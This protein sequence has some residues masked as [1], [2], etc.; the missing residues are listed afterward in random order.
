[1]PTAFS[2]GCPAFPVTA[3][4]VVFLNRFYWPDTAAT[5]QMLTDLAEGLAARGWEVS[6]IAGA[7]AYGAAV[8]AASRE[9]RNGVRIFRVRGTSLG[10]DRV[11]FRAIDQGTYMLASALRLGRIPRT[12][13]V[14]AMSDPPLVLA[15]AVALARARGHRVVYWL[16]DVYPQLAARLGVIRE[17]GI[18][19]RVWAALLRALYARCGAI[20]A[21][22]PAMAREAVVAGA[23]PDRTVVVSNWADTSA[24]RP[25]ASGASALAQAHGLAGKFVVLYSGNAGLAHTFE[26]VIAAA[27][28]LRDDPRIV[29]LFVG[30]GAKRRFIER[31]AVKHAL[32]NIRFMP[33]V[34]RGEL[35]ALLST[36]N[37]GLITEDPSAAGL[38][39]PS[40]IYGILAAGLPVLFVGAAHSDVAAIVRD[41]GCGYVVGPDDAA[42]VVG[43]IHRLQASP[44]HAADLGSRGRS[45]AEELYDRDTAVRA[46]HAVLSRVK[47]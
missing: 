30:G 43:A 34:P 20:V 12:D 41:S 45:T 29:F 38:L 25:A 28:R 40:K 22:G 1:M 44:G 5:A 47:S 15:V 11:A 26:A 35:G 17:R 9:I 13:V 32:T 31:E 33:A 23:P 2:R 39:L 18:V 46:W 4:S 37:V 36:G 42:G 24:I 21:L 6:V 16:Q 27:V 7:T 10:R 14:V 8:P 19:Y 3:G